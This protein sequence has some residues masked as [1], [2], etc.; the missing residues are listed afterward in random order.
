MKR[1]AQE[2]IELYVNSWNNTTTDATRAAF[3]ECWAAD[4]KYTDPNFECIEAVDGIPHLSGVSE[5]RLPGRKFHIVTPPQYHHGAC[6]YTWGVYIPGQDERQ[7]VD[8]VEFNDEMK[9]SRLVSFFK[10]L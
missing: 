6:F 7:G 10:P 1:S 2:T 4:A 3:A 8:Y 5:E 9:I